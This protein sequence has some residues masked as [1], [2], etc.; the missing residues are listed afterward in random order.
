MRF[1]RREEIPVTRDRAGRRRGDGSTWIA[2][3]VAMGTVALLAVSGIARDVGAQELADY[4]YENLGFRGVGIEGGYLVPDNVDQTYSVGVRV[5]LGYL[6]PGLRI[7]PSA[8]YW[9]SD[10][11]QREVGAL[12][13]RLA[14]LVVR[15][16]GTARPDVDL[17][18]IS[19]TDVALGVDG[20]FVWSIPL[21]L[22]GYAGA[23]ASA[24]VLDGRGAAIEGTFIEDLLDSVRAGFNLHGGLEYPADERLRLYSTTRYEL[25][26]DLRYLEVRLGAQIMLGEPAPGEEGR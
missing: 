22:L 10:L 9:S 7:V 1:G 6:G 16:T 24:H 8:T 23:G 13:D 25:L 15:E 12:E 17:G 11:K 18:V 26:G 19:W 3:L 4:D 14:D 2:A 20:H 5:D 21:G